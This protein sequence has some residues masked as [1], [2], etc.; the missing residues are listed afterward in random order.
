MITIEVQHGR[1]YAIRP[2]KPVFLSA[3][4]H[5]TSDT[6]LK[7]RLDLAILTESIKI[8]NST[9]EKCEGELRLLGELP[10]Q[11]YQLTPRVNYL[12]TKI[13]ASQKKIEG[14][15]TESAGLKKVLQTDF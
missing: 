11:P 1:P 14:Y 15:E 12:L 2:G 10:K 8:E 9:I 4:R 13:D 5:L 3:F 6:V 7:S